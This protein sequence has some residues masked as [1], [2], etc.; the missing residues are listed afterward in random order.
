MLLAKDLK[1]ESPTADKVK[2]NLPGLPIQPQQLKTD[3][4]KSCMKI[5]SDILKVSWEKRLCMQTGN[6]ISFHCL[7]NLGFLN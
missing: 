6:L 2:V 7:V 5:E 4:G 1:V 3:N